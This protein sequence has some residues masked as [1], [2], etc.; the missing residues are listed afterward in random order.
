MREVVIGHDRGEERSGAV[1]LFVMK[2]RSRESRIRCKEY[3]TTILDCGP[4]LPFSERK[5]VPHH[6]N[7]ML[8]S[9][10]R[11]IVDLIF[12]FIPK[13]ILIDLELV[14]TFIVARTWNRRYM[15]VCGN[16]LV[17]IAFCDN[18]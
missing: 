15:E 7:V 3:V 2:C 14:I 16:T 8:C 10:R 5:N 18:Y 4:F 6:P 12:N 17:K 1:I 11:D 9:F 13:L